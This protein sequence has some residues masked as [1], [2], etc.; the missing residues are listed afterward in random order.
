MTPLQYATMIRI[1]KAQDLLA[2]ENMNVSE[3][4][5][6]TDYNDISYFSRQFKAIIGFPPS[7]YLK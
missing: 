2:Y 4:A 7:Y 1:Y 6:Y 5:A 3:A